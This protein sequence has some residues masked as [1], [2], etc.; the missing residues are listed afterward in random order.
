MFHHVYLL[1]YS[2]PGPNSSLVIAGSTVLVYLL[3]NA[4]YNIYF[5]PLRRFPGPVSHAI[6]RIPYFYRACSGTLP[7]DMLSLHTRYGD[8][9]RI[10]P[11]ELAFSHPDAWKDIMGHKNGLPEM[12]KADWFYRPLVDEPLHVVNEDNDQ[13]KRLRRQLAYGFSEKGMREQEQLI[14]GYVEILLGKLREMA[15]TSDAITISDWYNFTT[16]D[17]I[18]DL[19]F[20]QPFGCLEGSAYDMWI[21]SIFDTG[22]LGSY[23]QALTF[24]PWLRSAIMALVPQSVK[25][26]AQR[27]KDLAKKK[28]LQ[29]MA[30]PGDRADLIE[31]LLKK[32]DQLD[33]SVEH[34]IANAEILIIGGSETTASLL[35]GVT[36]L[37]LRNPESYEKLKDEIRSTFRTQEDINMASVNRLT[38]MLACL[39]EALRMYPPIANGLPRVTPKGGAAVMGQYIPEG[40][41]VSIHQWALYRREDYFADPN[42]YHPDRFMGNVKFTNDR[43]EAFQPFHFGPR[44]CIGRNLAYSEMRLIL[45]LIIFKF[46]MTLADESVNWM[47]QKNFLMWQ[48][49]PLKVYI[50][51]RV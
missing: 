48:K 24:Y 51:P 49:G 29:R 19:A 3:T 36:Y 17:I 13:H 37:L 41:N 21:K 46:D 18:G 22:H 14:R 34:L 43:R 45:A 39:D 31:G 27:H 5:H 42:T 23:L 26:G 30:M 12:A 4:I 10:A 38:Y 7:F 47:N 35:S 2:L 33:L 44:N 15:G 8:I 28:M 40:T 20:G 6:S 25:D 9:V 50:T 16:F 32:K 1:G 11:D